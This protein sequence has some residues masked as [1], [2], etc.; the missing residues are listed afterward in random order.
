M[1]QRPG[2]RSGLLARLGDGG[3]S[4]TGLRRVLQEG[5]DAGGASGGKEE[6]EEGQFSRKRCVGSLS[7][8]HQSDV[9]P[10]GNR[11]SSGT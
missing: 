6:H 8:Q 5:V 11:I 3:D 2:T 1:P 4:G 7:G 9:V 10:H